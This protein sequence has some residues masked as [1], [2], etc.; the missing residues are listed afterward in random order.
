MSMKDF[1]ESLK[2]GLQSTADVK[3]VYGEPIETQD[4]TVIPVAKV[5]YGFGGGYGEAKGE[6]KDGK[7]GEGGGIGGGVAVKPLG[8]IEVTKEDTR[9]IP[10]G[11][12]KKL[13]GALIIGFI[14]GLL[15]GRK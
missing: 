11:S 1:F 4:K 15:F 3:A 14:L 8:V 12:K 5:A 2:D 13:V 6:N 10:L 9:Y 7:E